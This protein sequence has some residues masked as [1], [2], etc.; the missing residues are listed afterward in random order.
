MGELKAERRALMAL[1]AEGATGVRRPLTSRQRPPDVAIQQ[2][3]D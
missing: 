1:M 2:S 3:A